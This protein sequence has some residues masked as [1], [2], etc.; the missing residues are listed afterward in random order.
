MVKNGEDLRGITSDE[1]GKY[2]LNFPSFPKRDVMRHQQRENIGLHF[3]FLSLY[4]EFFLD[5]NCSHYGVLFSV[6]LTVCSAKVEYQELNCYRQFFFFLLFLFVCFCV[7]LWFIF[8]K[9]QIFRFV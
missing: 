8:C 9:L 2:T 1:L 3:E 6:V 5:C 7:G 4:F